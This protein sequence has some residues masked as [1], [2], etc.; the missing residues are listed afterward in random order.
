VE[1]ALEQK[2]YTKADPADLTLIMSVG[3]QNRLQFESFGAL[4]LQ[5]DVY[6]YTEGKLAVDAFDT[7]TKQAVWHGVASEEVHPDRTNPAAIDAAV[8]QLMTKFPAS[9]A[10][11][12]AASAAP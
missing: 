12:S 1:T 11:A 8:A 9:G 7:K 3:A 2:G 4:G 6:Q 5:R 10:P